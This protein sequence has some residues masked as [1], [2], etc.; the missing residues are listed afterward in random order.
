M[1]RIRILVVDDE[2]DFLKLIKRRLTKRNVDVETVT[3]GEDALAFLAEHPVDVVILD[4]RMPGLSGIDTLKEI[5]KRFRDL[6]VIMLTGHG[7]MQSGIEGINLG[8]YDYILKP[9]SIDN[10][11]DRIRAAHEHARLRIERRA[12]Q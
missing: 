2:H 10:L 1:T 11:L 9:F 12:Q 7:S 3:N 4:V 8:A 6:E 5:R